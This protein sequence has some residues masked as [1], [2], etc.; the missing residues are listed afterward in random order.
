MTP[1]K[2]CSELH[3]TALQTNPIPRTMPDGLSQRLK[4]T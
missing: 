4:L 2:S 1:K 3:N